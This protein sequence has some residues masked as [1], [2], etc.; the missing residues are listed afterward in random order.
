[1]PNC[2]QDLNERMIN[3]NTAEGMQGFNTYN[4][5]SMQQGN[6]NPMMN[7]GMKMMPPVMNGSNM[8]GNDGMMSMGMQ[9]SML[10]PMTPNLPETL[11]S[12]LYNAGYLRT[13]IGK[14][15]RV[16]FLVGDSITD[17]VGILVSVGASYIILQ[18]LDPSTLIMCDLYSI[19]FASIINEP[20][21]A[22]PGLFQ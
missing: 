18:S 14:L 17:R 12:P 8:L 21:I 10:N 2:T 5:A 9:G 3:E 7:T 20:T 19:K 15:M 11:T 13:Q 22:A 6:M 16:E 4:Q 1:M